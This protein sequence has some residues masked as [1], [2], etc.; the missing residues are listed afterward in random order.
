MVR[1]DY[2]SDPAAVA[3]DAIKYAEAKNMM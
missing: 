3:F 1:H 2:N